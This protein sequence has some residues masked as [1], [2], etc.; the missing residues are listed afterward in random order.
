MSLHVPR[1][2]V[3]KKKVAVIGAGATGALCALEIAKT[4]KCHV[5]LIDAGAPG[6]GSSSR[7]A[8]CFRQQFG[9]ES[10][11]RGM[12]YAGKY[13]DNWQQEVGGKESPLIRQGY[14][15]LKGFDTD[16]EALGKL[17]AN[18]RDYGLQEVELLSRSEVEERFHH[19]STVGIRGATWCPSDGFLTHDLVYL[20]AV[21]QLRSMEN[22]NIIL[23]Q[24][25]IGC[26]KS[27]SGQLTSLRLANQEDILVDRVVNATN[28]WAPELSNL[29]G[30]TE[31]R[32]IPRKRYLYHVHQ[33]DTELLKKAEFAKLPMTITPTGAY[34][35]PTPGGELMMGLLHFTPGTPNPA[36][37]TQDVIEPG[38]GGD[39]QAYGRHVFLKIERYVQVV[40]GLEKKGIQPTCGYYADTPDHNPII[41]FDP[42][43]PN[44]VH[45]A[46]FS[47][48]GLMHAPFTARIVTELVHRGR[49]LS[50]IEL[51]GFGQ[52]DIKPYWVRRKYICPEGMV[53]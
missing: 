17:V 1:R 15:F 30:G 32:I 20:D 7:S 24:R 2:G 14:L 44:L 8:A 26:T 53:L 31:L 21:Q 33:G 3:K 51:P 49:R 6:N 13:Y 19:I 42:K 50:T 10:T 45:A 39:P 35:R 47:G 25:V 12:R 52:V 16:F 28:A 22:V 48:H 37:D 18:Q 11:V 34:V 5:T 41:D 29:F 36:F 9:T 46:G 4:G 40:K 43:V 23:H 27:S 38:F